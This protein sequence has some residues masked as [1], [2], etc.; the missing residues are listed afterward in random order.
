[1]NSMIQW[2]SAQC[3][4]NRLTEKW[5]LAED[6]R[7]AQQWKDRVNLRGHSTVNLHSKTL[8]TIA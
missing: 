2:L 8:A 7:I 6:L 1:M 3:L 4:E 5:L